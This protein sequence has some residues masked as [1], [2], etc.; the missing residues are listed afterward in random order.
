MPPLSLIM[1]IVLAATSASP[2]PTGL[3]LRGDGNAYV[4]IA[5]C[6]T[7]IC[8]TNTWIKDPGTGEAVGDR[9][10]MDLAPQAGNVLSGTAYD[11]KRGMT[12]TVTVTVAPTGLTTRGCLLFGLLCR[13]V[14]WSRVPAS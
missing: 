9:L 13:S 12:Y 3:W 14:A 4:R 2:D 10:V 1:P 5:P 7:R 6:G 11:A 8:A